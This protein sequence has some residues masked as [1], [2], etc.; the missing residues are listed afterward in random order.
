MTPR[1]LIMAGGTGGHVFPALAVAE[2][3]LEAGVEVHWMG[4]RKGFEGKVVPPSI[5]FHGLAVKGLRGKGWHA[6]AMAPFNL[7]AALSQAMAIMGRVRPH[8]VLGMGGFA[9]GPGGL[10]AWL[11][12]RPLLIHEQNALPGLTNRWLAPLAAERLEGFA[13]S[14]GGRGIDVGNPVRRSIAALPPPEERFENRKGPLRLLVLGGSQGA[15]AINCIVPQAL[16]QLPRPWEVW[17][18]AGMRHMAETRKCYQRAGVAARLVPFIEDMASAYAWADV[19]LGRSGALTVA[20]L[21]CAGVGAV[22][23]PYPHAVDDHQTQNA[24][25]LEQAGAAFLLPQPRLTASRLAACL[26]TLDRARLRGMAVHA[27]R[28]ARPDAAQEVA[29]HCLKFC[30]KKEKALCH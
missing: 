19:V 25:F 10:A 13:G 23:V 26:K 2:K 15:R 5:P 22:L 6:W 21:A 12:R 30:Q 20:E 4:S 3:L 29:A 1:L 27:R 17:H 11:T 7:A 16:A 18:Q 14:F 28:L 8:A 24:R 9:S